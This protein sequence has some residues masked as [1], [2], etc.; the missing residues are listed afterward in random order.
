M[1][2]VS[3]FWVP[4]IVG[5]LALLRVFLIAIAFFELGSLFC[6]VAPLADFLIFGRIFAG[7]G[8]A[9]ICVSVLTIMAE[10]RLLTYGLRWLNASLDRAPRF[11]TEPSSSGPLAQ[12]LACR[13]S[14][15]PY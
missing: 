3:I 14:W 4:L 13:A 5:M 12:C 8:A 10:V 7:I 15:G 9:G 1:F 2:R 11:D 6:G